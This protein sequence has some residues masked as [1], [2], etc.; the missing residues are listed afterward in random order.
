MDYKEIKT[1]E[2]AFEAK[3]LAADFVPDVSTYPEEDRAH[4]ITDFKLK[5]VIAAINGD[6]K[7]DWTNTDQRKHYPWWWVLKD[8]SKVSGR[9]LSLYDVYCDYSI[10]NVGPRLVF[11]SREKAL[12][13][14]EHFKALYEEWYF[15]K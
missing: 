11:A 7:I 15:G 4:M 5:T 12:H 1:I 2:Q 13:G 9:G 8:E 6:E 10:T 3:G 14:A